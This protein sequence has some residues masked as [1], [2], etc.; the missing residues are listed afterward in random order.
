MLTCTRSLAP[1]E[2][3]P[4]PLLEPK[5]AERLA[6]VGIAQAVSNSPRP[7]KKAKHNPW[8][9]KVFPF[10]KLPGHLNQVKPKDEQKVR[11]AS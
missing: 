2:K 5:I 10:K 8:D 6:A 11:W 3:Y 4:C 1:T 9:G 7:N